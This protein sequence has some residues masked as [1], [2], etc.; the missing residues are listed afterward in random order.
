[1][2]RSYQTWLLSTWHVAAAA[3]VVIRS[4]GCSPFGAA[5]DASAADASFDSISASPD[6]VADADAPADRE[7]VVFITR[8]EYRGDLGGLTGA[9]ALCNSEAPAGNE[10]VKS[11]AFVAWLS[12]HATP[13][14]APHVHGTAPYVLP[15]GEP[16][17]DDWDRFT[18]GSLR[19]AI[20]EYASSERVP[21]DDWYVWTG[22]VATGGAATQTC[23]DWRTSSGTSR[24]GV[25]H[26][27]AATSA[28]TEKETHDCSL[29]HP[30]Y[31]VQK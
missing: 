1:V 27:S 2:L 17:A 23:S 18:S 13:A 12:T 20:D 19:H 6:A 8:K 14:A 10:R 16:V 5:P 7:R 22:T 15:S 26:A 9:D 4:V 25:G 3:A 21:T 29:D 24:G 11:H 31:C 28:W 30:I